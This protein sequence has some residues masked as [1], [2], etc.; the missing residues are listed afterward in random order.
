MEVEVKIQLAGAAEARRLR[1]GLAAL[2]AT[3]TGTQTQEDTFYAPSGTARLG[4]DEAL[5]LR[6]AGGRII[7]THKGPRVPG[8]GS[9]KRREEVNVTTDAHAPDLLRALGFVPAVRLRKRRESY[10]WRKVDIALD[11]LQGLGYFVEVEART[12]RGAT[13]AIDRALGALGLAGRPAI[14]ESY[15]ELALKHGAAAVQSLA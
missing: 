2:G 1:L 15:V 6:R 8:R 11:H 10:A 3:Q 9:A 12:G 14:R 5:R 7:L 13:A 4:P